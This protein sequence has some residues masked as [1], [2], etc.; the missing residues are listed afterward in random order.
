VAGGV[1]QL[2]ALLLLL[3]WAYRN[4]GICDR[5]IFTSASV[6]GTLITGLGE[7][8]NP[9]GFRALDEER[10]REAMAQ[11]ISS[12]WS[13]EGDI[14]FRDLFFKSVQEQPA[15]YV[16][17]VVKRLPLV[18]ATPYDLFFQNPWKISTFSEARKSGE[19]HYQVLIR[20][21]WYVLAAYWDHLAMGVFTLGC[22]LATLLM[23]WKERW[24]LALIFLL[25]TPHL[26]SIGA[27]I[28]THLE[29]RFL[30]PSMFCWLI[31][32]GYVLSRIHFS[33]QS[34]TDG[35]SRSALR[36]DQLIER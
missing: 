13:C 20:R 1:I 15:A 16:I 26:Y 30:L 7:F 22:F 35:E 21:P 3:P 17:A 28:L 34:L 29:P 31:G 19:D 14:Y 36:F 9:W 8:H 4:Y 25:I 18:L 11:G 5:W 24:Q 27:H 32:P 2:V 12:P 6:G 10:A 33:R 23:A